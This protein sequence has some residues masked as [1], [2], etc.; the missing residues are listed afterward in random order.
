MFPLLATQS[1]KLYQDGNLPS[2]DQ[3]HS[4]GQDVF[5][6]RNDQGVRVVRSR[7]KQIIVDW[8]GL[9]GIFLF[10]F[11]FYMILDPP[12]Q[13]FHVNDTSLMHP[14][15]ESHVSSVL[16][17]LLSVFFP[18]FVILAFYMLFTG[19]RWDLYSGIYGAILAYALALFFTSMLWKFVGG[20]RPHFLSLCQVD[21]SKVL[22]ETAYY[23]PSVC[24]NEASF[25]RDTFHGF[26][27]GHASTAFAGCV[28]LSCYLA[29]HLRLYR[30]A[31][32]GKLLLVLLPIV[33]ASW[34]AFSRIAD[35]HHSPIQ[36][37]VGI[38]IG[39]LSA[40]LAYRLV[41]M[42]GFWLGYGR[43]A[44]V[45]FLHGGIPP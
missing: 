45:P 26:P 35:H 36:L 27:S 20:L 2:A 9:A 17:A 33:C 39:T 7:R 6:R 12:T 1:A 41:Y 11:L 42:N 21:R 34:L 31:N 18:I 40:M 10:V 8:L 13:Y 30:G 32:T 43:W 25:T 37:L 16:V 29:A 44:H 5:I 3:L 23:T 15:Q 28:F 19:D 4:T 22:S 38:L 24:K 14:V